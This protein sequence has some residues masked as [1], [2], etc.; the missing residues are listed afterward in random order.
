MNKVVHF[1]TCFKMAGGKL[2]YKNHGLVHM[3]YSMNA[4]GNPAYFSTYEDDHENGEVA[5]QAKAAHMLRFAFTVLQRS[6]VQE[7]HLRS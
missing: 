3:V 6:V 4:H 1:N 7:T 5:I 2:V